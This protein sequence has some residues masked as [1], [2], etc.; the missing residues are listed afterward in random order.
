MSELF[1]GGSFAMCYIGDIEEFEWRFVL[2]MRIL[3]R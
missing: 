3:I 2:W 1:S